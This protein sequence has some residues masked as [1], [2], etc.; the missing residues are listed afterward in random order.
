MINNKI[1]KNYSQVKNYYYYYYFERIYKEEV[2]PEALLKNNYLHKREE[3]WRPFRKFRINEKSK[4]MM[5]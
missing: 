5:L 3:G 2:S 4:N 1:L